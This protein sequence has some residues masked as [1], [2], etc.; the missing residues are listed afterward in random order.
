MILVLLW[1]VHGRQLHLRDVNAIDEL[2][3]NW[4]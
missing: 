1:G 2:D 4:I 3:K